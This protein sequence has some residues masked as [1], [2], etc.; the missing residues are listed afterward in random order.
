LMS[1]RRGIEKTLNTI[2]IP[3]ARFVQFFT[4][5]IIQKK[6]EELSLIQQAAPFLVALDQPLTEPA[7][8][9]FQSLINNANTNRQTVANPKDLIEKWIKDFDSPFK[10]SKKFQ[11][12]DLWVDNRDDVE[13]TIRLIAL[14]HAA[15]Q[16]TTVVPQQIPPNFHD[17]IVVVFDSWVSGNLDT[18]TKAY[19]DLLDTDSDG[20]LNENQ[21]EQLA[22]LLVSPIQGAVIE[23]L[24][25]I[26]T[27]KKPQKKSFSNI[28]NQFLIDEKFH[29]YQ[30]ALFE[31]A[32]K[33]DNR[34]ISFQE[35]ENSRNKNFELLN[36]FSQ[37]QITALENYRNDWYENKI[38]LRKSIIRGGFLMFL[39]CVLDL[40][41]VAL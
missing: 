38:K 20:Q 31:W 39:V 18:R 9:F 14:Q 13:K 40:S 8:N 16:L 6:N 33:S 35:L 2:S 5:S 21:S 30:K 37:A 25:Q 15:K 28:A 22:W 36:N 17:K 1:L 34:L 26:S 27:F 3:Y 24:N 4:N 7:Q 29:A 10:K 41:I 23:S 11:T 19:F 32:E 12:I